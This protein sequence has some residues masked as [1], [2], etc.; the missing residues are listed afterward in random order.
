M[1]QRYPGGH[2][3][4]W[5]KCSEIGQPK[6]G[7]GGDSVQAKA[8][9]E[10]QPA[11]TALEHQPSQQPQTY[12]SFN[13]DR[14]LSTTQETLGSI[15]SPNYSG[16]SLSEATG[17]QQW[18]HE[19]VTF[20]FAQLEDSV[21]NFQSYPTAT[22]LSL[23]TCNSAPSFGFSSAT[24]EEWAEGCSETLPSP[25]TWVNSNG[26]LLLETQDFA[27]RKQLEL[28]R[29]GLYNN[30]LD[31]QTYQDPTS[32]LAGFS[33]PDFCYFPW[34]A[35][36]DLEMGG[37]D[38]FPEPHR[39]ALSDLAHVSRPEEECEQLPLHHDFSNPATQQAGFPFMPHY[40]GWTDMEIP[41][42]PFSQPSLANC[43]SPSR[44][45][46]QD[47]FCHNVPLNEGQM[48][49]S[50]PL[51]LRPRE[52]PQ[53]P[54]PEVAGMRGKEEILTVSEDSQGTAEP[55]TCEDQSPPCPSCVNGQQS[56]VMVTYKLQTPGPTEK[57]P[58]KPRARLEEDARRQTCRTR[59]LGACVRC[60]IQRVRVFKHRR[61]M[62][63]WD[64]G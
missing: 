51:V 54:Q 28:G 12:N 48:S 21:F 59:S 34:T 27:C 58:P 22:D 37:G 52:S 61:H 32:Y 43:I 49:Q 26:P 23:S 24:H 17:F 25:E 47:D 14:G 4:V 10:Q 38:Y 31:H 41:A 63:Y 44:S 56:W 57:K 53:T 5:H 60:K 46:G 19:P 6:A 20:Q 64:T 16:W 1:K 13:I 30:S 8:K 11:K 42:Q 36:N 18:S 55:C 50:D 45:L 33:H 7:F 9:S 15:I 29:G 39:A 62:Y 2:I 35:S 3:E 40:P